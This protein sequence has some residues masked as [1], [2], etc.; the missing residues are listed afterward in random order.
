MDA[1]LTFTQSDIK[2]PIYI[3][4]PPGYTTWMPDTPTILPPL[5]TL[6]CL[7]FKALYGLKQ[8]VILWL[9]KIQATL[10]KLRFIPLHSDECVYRN[11]I[12]RILIITY[13]D[14]FLILGA[15]LKAIQELK[16]RL[17][18]VLRI[19]DL[20]PVQQFCRTR[21]IRDR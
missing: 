16:V 21:I 7:L 10:R 6:A 1:V 13:M 14:D 5:K 9:K 15:S 20:G 18:S 11:P 19:E 2:D 3:E 4:M 17:K 12:T 8:S